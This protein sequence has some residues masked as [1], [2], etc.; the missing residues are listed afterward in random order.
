[1]SILI[2]NIGTSDIAVKVDSYFL[3]IGFN[4]REPNLEEPS[5]DTPEG[6]AWYERDITLKQ[7]FRYKL[8]LQQE[9]P[10][11]REV[12]KALLEQYKQQP[13][14]W[15]PRISI[16][17]IQGVI[18]AALKG[19]DAIQAHLVVT[20]QTR[21]NQQRHPT[22]TIY[23]VELIE[24]VLRHQNDS[25]LMGDRPKLRLKQEQI[26]FSAIDEDRLYNYYAELFEQIHPSKVVYV[27]VKGGTPQMQQAL[28]AHALAPHTQAQIFISPKLRVHDILTGQS[29]DCKRVSY[30]R[31]QKKQKYQMVQLLLNRWDFDGAAALLSDWLDTLHALDV[32][33][34]ERLSEHQK[35]VEKVIQGLKMA[36][37]YLNLD[38]QSAENLHSDDYTLKALIQQFNPLENLYA[39][40]KLY[41]E[42]KQISHFLSRLGSFYE[43]TQNELIQALGGL[44]Y[45]DTDKPGYWQVSAAAVK[46]DSPELW[47]L[48][49]KN[50]EGKEKKL[51]D[52]WQ[53]RNRFDKLKY[54]KSLIKH[55]YSGL[56]TPKPPS[57]ED[58]H[59]LN[60]WY[61][62]RNQ[63][64]HGSKGI[65]EDRMAAVYQQRENKNQIACRYEEILPTMQSI[66]N[67]IER[68]QSVSGQGNDQSVFSEYG[69]YGH[70]REWAIA[71][72]KS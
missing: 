20:N 5:A 29:S 24:R 8:E 19:N 23:A 59:R 62:I 9:N 66:L 55:Q 14:V 26:T 71:S 48:L 43:A 70:V 52:Y 30:W 36:I 67:T 16:G 41:T 31:Y 72:L 18:Q 1:M 28:R 27:S 42:L 45:I 58:W 21:D 51:R 37:A 13:D 35:Q 65:N 69:L 46:A 49:Q 11:F 63:L 60:F 50:F 47:H 44:S 7:F 33:D 38:L 64:V 32:D 3:P 53:L 56:S 40:C 22:D 54:I 25:L 12:S 39:Q 2:A 10:S 57:L 15:H 61:G 17:R 68:V 6:V 34:F 4:R